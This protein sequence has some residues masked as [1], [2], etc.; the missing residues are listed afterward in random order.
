MSLR[1]D[2]MAAAAE[3]IAGLERSCNGGNAEGGPSK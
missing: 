3:I 2:P 1:K